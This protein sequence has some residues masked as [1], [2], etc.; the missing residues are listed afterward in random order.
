MAVTKY[1]LNEPDYIEAK[2]FLEEI[3]AMAIINNVQLKKLHELSTRFGF[4]SRP[5]GCAACNRR[6]KGYVSGFVHEY[7]RI[8]IN[9]EQE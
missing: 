7:E 1:N 4:P 3:N 2:A 6:A 9:G 8:V 5:G